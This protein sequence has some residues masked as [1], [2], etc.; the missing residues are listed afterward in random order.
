MIRTVRVTT[1]IVNTS[2]DT[3]DSFEPETEQYQLAQKDLEE[4]AD[5]IGYNYE[6]GAC[7]YERDDQIAKKRVETQRS[8][9]RRAVQA[10]V[11]AQH[12]V[13]RDTVIPSKVVIIYYNDQIENMNSYMFPPGEQVTWGMVEDISNTTNFYSNIRSNNDCDVCIINVNNI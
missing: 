5:E 6:I 13:R 8:K 1:D 12:K 7:T 9:F 10:A 2:Y 11:V 3:I 4:I